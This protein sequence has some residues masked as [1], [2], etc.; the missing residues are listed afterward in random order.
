MC[1]GKVVEI[2]HFEA[3]VSAWM[4]LETVNQK[5]TVRCT[6]AIWSRCWRC[7]LINSRAARNVFAATVNGC[8]KR[9]VSYIHSR[10]ERLPA[11]T[12]LCGTW[13]QNSIL[14]VPHRYISQAL[15]F[16]YLWCC[17]LYLFESL[18]RYRLHV[19]TLNLKVVPII[20]IFVRASGYLDC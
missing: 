12:M 3:T 13:E 18:W 6:L 1:T 17:A 10:W 19:W 11:T 16:P 20:R 2:A 4:S 9:L 14:P 15:Q 5:S 8:G 7:T